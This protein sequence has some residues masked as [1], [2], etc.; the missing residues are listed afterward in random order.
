MKNQNQPVIKRIPAINTPSKYI[1]NYSQATNPTIELNPEYILQK[2]KNPSPTLKPQS[3]NSNNINEELSPIQKESEI[4]DD[5][6]KKINFSMKNIYLSNR[7]KKINNAKERYPSNYSYYESKYTKKVS[8]PG[9][10]PQNSNSNYKQNTYKILNNNA[11]SLYYSTEKIIG[12]GDGQIGNTLIQSSDRSHIL[13]P[14]STIKID[15][16]GHN[17]F[18]P[19]NKNS[20]IFYSKIPQNKIIYFQK[21]TINNAKKNPNTIIYRDYYKNAK[22]SEKIM[23]PKTPSTYSQYKVKSNYKQN[24]NTNQSFKKYENKT[25]NKLQNIY[26]KSLESVAFTNQ[27]KNLKNINI[28]N[29]IN[30]KQNNFK[31]VVKYTNKNNQNSQNNQNNKNENN[32]IQPFRLSGD[33]KN[34]KFNNNNPNNINNTIVNITYINENKNYIKNIYTND[35]LKPV[36]QDKFILHNENDESKKEQKNNINQTIDYKYL[37]NERR[38]PNQGIKIISTNKMRLYTPMN[39]KTK[40][41]NCQV[42]KVEIKNNQKNSDKNE[43]NNMK[44]TEIIIK[45]NKNN[46]YNYK[47][48]NKSK[49]DND[50]L[51]NDINMDKKQDE[52]KEEKISLNIKRKKDKSVERDYELIYNA[53]IIENKYRKKSNEKP[54][55]NISE[56]DTIAINKTYYPKTASKINNK[57]TNQSF[58]N[59]IKIQNNNK[60]STIISQNINKI[61]KET[62]NIHSNI[63]NL[64]ITNISSKKPKII[65]IK[66][67]AEKKGINDN[68]NNNNNKYIKINPFRYKE[69]ESRKKTY[70]AAKNSKREKEKKNI[71]EKNKT[72]KEKIE[73]LKNCLGITL[74]G[75]NEKGI[76]KINQDT[77]FIEKKV[78][79]IENFNI[80]GVLD[81][82]GDNGHLASKFVK[83]YVIDQI[84]NNPS[85]KHLKDPEKIYNSII[86]DGYQFLAKIYLE[87]DIEIQNQGFDT[88][89]SGTTCIIII[90]IL[91]HI[92]CSN[93]GDS[94]AMIVYDSDDNLF[95]SQIYPLSYDCKPELP[96]EKKRI[97]ELGGVVEKAYY[98]DDEDGENSGPY[99]VWAKGEDYPGLAMSRSIGDMDAKKVG[100]IPNPQIVEYTIDKSSKYFILASDGIWEFISNEE[101]MKFANP[102]YMRNDCLGL[103]KELS[104]IATNLWKT[105]DIIIDDITC[106]AGF[107]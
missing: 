12:F 35:L 69:K 104:Q 43:N 54:I 81:G 106:V 39:E 66:K 14:K 62:K 94:R 36:I 98:S 63:S 105:K 9:N 85:I 56:K 92:I 33:E 17:T 95:Q 57:K 71:N 24:V 84:K 89:R 4:I 7:N 5:S 45:D 76:K 37:S 19:M 40:N 16:N 52:Q 80:F 78:N 73:Y 107:F 27:L 42:K 31:K 23:Q 3:A 87:A 83:N 59:T 100:V 13:S 6:L 53:K 50:D 44:K 22:T 49:V 88:S 70:D 29:N 30:F 101:C 72:K 47:T 99:R 86:S 32:I 20:E 74:A 61:N 97:M 82:H 34:N 79:G 93:T 15:N 67:K 25:E 10:Q 41:I 26:S 102:F 75:R 77:F 51:K 21:S 68:N 91:N 58:L 18:S 65:V 11:R 38:T 55:S 60:I 28:N 2:E 1:T 103:C 46:N 64:T 96:N 90:Q 8:T 48:H